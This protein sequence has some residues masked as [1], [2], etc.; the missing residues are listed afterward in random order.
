MW[1]GCHKKEK[2]QESTN[3]SHLPLDQRFSNFIQVGTT[4]IKSDCSTD[5]PTLVPF[6]SKLF[7][8]LN[9]GV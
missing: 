5:R 2:S 9:Y 7:E 3:G 4:F 8:I 1:K 6:E